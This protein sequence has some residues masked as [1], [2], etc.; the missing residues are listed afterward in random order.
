MEF[1]LERK[2]SEEGKKYDPWFRFHYPN[3][4]Y[5]DIL[6]GLD[7]ITSLGYASDKRL[8]KTLR[9]LKKKQLQDGSWKLDSIH[10]DVDKGAD[11]TLKGKTKKFALEREGE[12]SK[13]IT[14]TSLKVLKRV[15][16]SL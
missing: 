9:Y 14:L 11:Y 15:E 7:V 2:L 8:D 13:W 3:H 12:P 4:Y 6:V 5:Y 10:P 16:E 1:Y